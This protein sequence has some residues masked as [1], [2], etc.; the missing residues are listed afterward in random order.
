M[1]GHRRG[2]S[3]K[4]SKQSIP[5]RLHSR[6]FFSDGCFDFPK[7]DLSLPRFQ[8]NRRL[9][10]PSRPVRLGVRTLLFQ[11]GNTGSIPVRATRKAVANSNLQRL[12]S[13]PAKHMKKPEKRRSPTRMCP[14]PVFHAGTAPVRMFRPLSDAGSKIHAFRKRSCRK[15]RPLPDHRATRGNGPFHRVSAGK[16]RF[17]STGTGP[18]NPVP[19]LAGIF[20]WMQ[21]IRCIFRTSTLQDN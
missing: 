21:V 8:A 20:T 11:G 19:G 3:A 5:A 1:S 12:L 10:H 15:V 13:F 17:G 4:V 2:G 9:R 7:S 16:S 6:N 14:L 18:G